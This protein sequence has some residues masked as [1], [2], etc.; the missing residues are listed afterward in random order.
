MRKKVL[1]EVLCMVII[2]TTLFSMLSCSKSEDDLPTTYT[3]KWNFETYG[4]SNVTLFEYTDNGD[5]IANNT[6]DN[7]E[8]N[9][10]YTFTA[11]N[12]TVKVKIYFKMMSNVRWVQQVYYLEAGRNIDIVIQDDT[13]V[14]AKEP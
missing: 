14:G 2:A 8:K 9:G 4:I 13:K 5:K 12:K 7:L 1:F 3:L 11:D 6:V 10:S